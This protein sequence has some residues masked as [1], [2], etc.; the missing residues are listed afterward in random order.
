MSGV[1]VRITLEIELDDEMQEHF[2]P[3]EPSL[4]HQNLWDYLREGWLIHPLMRRCKVIHSH[5]IGE[6]D[7]ATKDYLMKAYDVEVRMGKILDK[8]MKVEVID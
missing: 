4:L 3:N 7:D 5:S 2:P 1:K 6:L 8:N